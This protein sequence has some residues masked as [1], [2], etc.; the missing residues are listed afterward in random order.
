MRE[1]LRRS[2]AETR[3]LRG[4]LFQA[5]SVIK[6]L[7]LSKSVQ[8]SRSRMN[9][10]RGSG[11]RESGED[12]RMLSP[13]RS[14][15]TAP[16]VA[17]PAVCDD[18]GGHARK[19]TIAGTSGVGSTSPPSDRMAESFKEGLLN[20]VRH[21]DRLSRHEGE[22]QQRLQPQHPVSAVAVGELSGSRSEVCAHPRARVC[23]MGFEGM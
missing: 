16:V 2:R 15:P 12:G 21:R 23:V 13:S 22:H 6:Q 3:D 20:R 7:T 17:A 1:A 8:K 11:E 14:A 10:S 19:Q 9:S 4:D 5:E 18:G